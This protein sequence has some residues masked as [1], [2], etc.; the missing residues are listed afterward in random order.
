[1]WVIDTN[2][3]LDLLHFGDPAAA[4]I[5]RALEDGRI[6]CRVTPA[7]L[8]ELRR[9]LVYPQLR[10]AAEVQAKIWARYRE[11]AHCVNAPSPSS[12]PRCRDADDQK[13]LELADAEGASVLVSKDRAL[14]RLARRRLRF[15]ILD[16]LQAAFG[17]AT[18]DAM[19][20]PALEVHSVTKPLCS[21]SSRWRR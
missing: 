16:P 5:L 18:V 8:Q 19:L 3:V 13:F 21:P 12:L 4:P 15:R 6:E 14:L 7:T 1:M 10:L 20:S 11:L 2:V 9:V 17:L